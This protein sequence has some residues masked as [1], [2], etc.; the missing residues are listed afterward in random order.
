MQRFVLFAATVLAAVSLNPLHSADPE[1]TPKTLDQLHGGILGEG[2]RTLSATSCA[3]ASCHGG[4]RPGLGNEGAQRANAYLLWLENDPHAKSWRTITGPESSQMLDRLGIVRDGQIVDL[5]GFNNCLACHNSTPLDSPASL[6]KASPSANWHPE[7]VGCGACHGPAE[8]WKSQHYLA[9]WDPWQASEDGFVPAGDMLTRARMCA[10]CHVGDSDRD[11]NHDIIAAGHPALYFEMTAYHDRLPKHWRDPPSQ[12]PALGDAELWIAGAIANADASLAL[13]QGQAEKKTA[14]STWPELSA[15]DCSSCHHS[16]RLGNQREPLADPTRRGHAKVS[17]WN[18]FGV[19]QLL[20]RQRREGEFSV[21]GEAVL[22]GLERIRSELEATPYPA[23]ER[24]AQT[25]ART[26]EHLARWSSPQ[27]SPGQPPLRPTTV[28]R[29]QETDQLLKFVHHA[30]TNSR[31][32]ATWEGAA[33]F[34][35]L[36]AASRNSWPAS[37]ESVLRKHVSY[38]RRGLAFP[39]NHDSPRYSITRPEGSGATRDE[40]RALAIEIREAL[41]TRADFSLPPPQ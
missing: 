38:L 15:Y 5:D 39:E 9:S 10:S 16:L 31:T 17:Q 36:T 27:P 7:G 26:R 18:V 1:R 34:Y 40:I 30:T 4:P 25:A 23:A 21:A 32:F 8:Q 11:M 41:G 12:V 19:Q 28:W 6:T 22:Q 24:I 2:V 35:L 20:E 33:Q 3:A 29:P 37:S 14:V 13:L